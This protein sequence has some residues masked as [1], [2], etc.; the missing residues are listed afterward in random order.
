MD[1]KKEAFVDSINAAWQQG[2]EAAMDPRNQEAFQKGGKAITTS[3]SFWLHSR[4][5]RCAHTF[6]SGDEVILE[7]G[8]AQHLDSSTFCRSEIVN[9]KGQQ[10]LARGSSSKVETFFSGLDE[11]WPPPEDILRLEEGHRLLAPP[12]AG[13]RRHSCLMCSHTFRLHDQVVI[14]PCSPDAPLC[15]AAIHR[16]PVRGLNC[17][18]SWNPGGKAVVYCPVTSRRLSTP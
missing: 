15:G 8:R 16:D 13:F 3:R 6:R 14:C 9:E 18:Q 12:V 2:F 4:C 17:L 10:K 5:N 7:Q 1:E 11:A